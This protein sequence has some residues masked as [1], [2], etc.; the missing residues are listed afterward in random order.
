V[1][2]SHRGGKF[3]IWYKEVGLMTHLVLPWHPSTAI[4]IAV[5][6][7]WPIMMVNVRTLFERINFNTRMTKGKGWHTFTNLGL[8]LPRKNLSSEKFSD[9]FCKFNIHKFFLKIRKFF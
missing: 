3:L 9:K 7:S 5:G 8:V 2:S 1:I 6:I 4:P